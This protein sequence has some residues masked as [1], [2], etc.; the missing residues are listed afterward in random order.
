MKQFNF[1]TNPSFGNYITTESMRKYIDIMVNPLFLKRGIALF[2][3]TLLF[4]NFE[5]KLDEWYNISKS[6]IT[7]SPN[8]MHK[9]GAYNVIPPEDVKNLLTSFRPFIDEYFGT[10]FTKDLVEYSNFSV[11]YSTSKDTKLDRHID[12]SDITINICLKNTFNTPETKILFENVQDTLYSMKPND[13]KETY[14][15]LK[16]GNILIHKG[17]HVHSTCKMNNDICD[18]DMERC[19]IILWFKF[20]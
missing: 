3:G 5:Q 18:N 14:V 1:P 13:I 17:N 15:T 4:P 20:V 9:Y 2:D 8:T 11:H 16:R 12:D 10:S 19:N 7:K 6:K